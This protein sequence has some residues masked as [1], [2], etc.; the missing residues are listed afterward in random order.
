MKVE[1]VTEEEAIAALPETFDETAN[2]VQLTE[3]EAERAAEL[4]IKAMEDNPGQHFFRIV[5]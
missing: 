4:L 1:P 3:E 5:V 2:D